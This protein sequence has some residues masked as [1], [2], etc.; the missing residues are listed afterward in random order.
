MTFN[1]LALF[2]ES[3]DH[4]RGLP[5]I[6]RLIYESKALLRR[7]KAA[8]DEVFGTLLELS[9]SK[10]KAIEA[11]LLARNEPERSGRVLSQGGLL[12]LLISE[13]TFRLNQVV[14]P[15]F[16]KQIFENPLKR[17]ADLLFALPHSDVTASLAQCHPDLLD[18]EFIGLV[19]NSTNDSRA[20]YG[21]KLGRWVSEWPG[22]RDAVLE[23]MI[24]GFPPKQME[25]MWLTNS[26][27]KRE[28][29]IEFI[30]RHGLDYGKTGAS[31]CAS[32]KTLTG[33]I[34][35]E[36][37]KSSRRLDD[38]VQDRGRTISD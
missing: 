3:R 13:V 20:I 23:A 34:I 36:H 7:R 22:I 4:P 25:A 28:D 31:N 33:L 38:R 32:L 37:C 11:E 18:S 30:A 27:G 26:R 5:D 24:S 19:I 8:A 14:T 15:E 2:W 10:N 12:W 9:K 6:L 17:P 21:L 16:C 35:K 29:V 1:E